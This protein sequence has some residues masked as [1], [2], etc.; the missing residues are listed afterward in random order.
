MLLIA[1]TMVVSFG[2]RLPVSAKKASDVILSCL[3]YFLE[4]LPT[5]IGKDVKFPVLSVQ[6]QRHWLQSG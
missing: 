3:R 6:W 1:L 4:G 5:N 2:T